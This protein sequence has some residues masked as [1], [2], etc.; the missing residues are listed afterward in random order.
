MKNKKILIIIILIIFILVGI[1]ILCLYKHRN[2]K[3]GT[4]Y[5]RIHTRRRDYAENN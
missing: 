5:N 4:K 3:K 1:R 2:I